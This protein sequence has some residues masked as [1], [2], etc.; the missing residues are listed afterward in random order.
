MDAKPWYKSQ[1]VWANLI[2]MVMGVATALGFIG[3]GTS[4]LIIAEAPGLI[5]SVVTAGLGLWGLYG[6]VT[7]KTKITT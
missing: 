2:I 7:A 1:G 6:R 4:A 3:E 5:V